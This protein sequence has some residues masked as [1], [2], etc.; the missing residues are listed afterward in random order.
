MQKQLKYSSIFIIL[1]FSLFLSENILA[2]VLLRHPDVS[3][4]EFISYLGKNSEYSSFKECFIEKHNYL[5]YK[6]TKLFLEAET[7]SDPVKQKILINLLYENLGRSFLSDQAKLLWFELLELEKKNHFNNDNDNDNT[8]FGD[9]ISALKNRDNLFKNKEGTN[10]YRLSELN[11][12]SDDDVFIN[13]WP[14]SPEERKNIILN[15]AIYYHFLLLSNTQSPFTELKKPDQ[16]SIQRTALVSGSCEDSK[17]NLNLDEFKNTEVLA[18]FNKNCL[19]K[20]SIL[21]QDKNQ[22]DLTTFSK[23]TNL[24]KSNWRKSPYTYGVLLVGFALLAASADL[25]NYRVKIS[26]PF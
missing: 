17:Y 3:E 5:D 9:Q 19:S 22:F 12:N 16:L 8:N 15:K 11:I 21:S 6:T 26:L 13:G 25:K 2:A 7:Q 20:A 4:Q 14:I 10:Y 24:F 18:L 1:F 23:D